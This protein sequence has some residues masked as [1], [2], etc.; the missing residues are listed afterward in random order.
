M[1][2]VLV[3]GANGLLGSNVVRQLS[4][5]GYLVKSMIRKGSDKSSLLNTKCELFEGEIT[6]ISDVRKAVADCQYIIHAA[7]NTSQ[8][9]TKFDSYK[10]TNIEAT[11]ILIEV[12]K[13]YKVKRFVF[14]ST[15]NCF[16]NGS[17]EQPG[18]ENSKF[19]PWLK[20]SGYAYSKYIAQQEVIRE[21]KENAFPA[22]IVNPTFLVGPYDYKPSSGKLLLYALNNRLLFYPP[23]GKSFVDVASA[24]RAISCALFRGKIGECY[25]LSGENLSY[26]RFYKEVAKLSGKRKIMIPIPKQFLLAI[27]SVSNILQGIFSLN[28]PLNMVNARLLCL[29]NY[30]SNQKARKDLCMEKTNINNSIKLAINWFSYKKYI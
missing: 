27:G 7:A 13:Q 28:L 6:N 26:K 2:K 15:A 4:N 10:K 12:A 16:T 21:V 9:N 17:M 1:E 30:F 29:D 19:M 3:T 22:I 8:S 14:V 23:G 24:S 25:L 20:E 11:K 18:T 5:Y